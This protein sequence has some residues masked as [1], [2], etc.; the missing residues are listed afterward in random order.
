MILSESECECKAR[1]KGGR[2]ID[3]RNWGWGNVRWECERGNQGRGM[4]IEWKLEMEK[5]GG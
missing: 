2:R 1:K 5:E 4:R 3:T